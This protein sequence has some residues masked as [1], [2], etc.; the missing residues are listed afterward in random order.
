MSSRPNILLIQSDQH[1]GQVMGCAGDDIVRTP[2]LDGLAESGVIFDNCQ[3][4]APL[5][6]PSRMTMLAGR[7]C[8]DIDVWSNQCR[9][10]SD[11]PTFAHALGAGGYETVLCGRMHFTGPDQRHGFQKRIFGELSDHRYWGAPTV[12]LGDVPLSTTGQCRESVEV[13]G[14]GRTSYQ[15]YDEEVAERA[16]QFLQQRDDDR[17]LFLT[18]GFVLPH[19]PFIAEKE[20]FEYYYDRVGVP[21]VPDGYC[22]DMPEPMRRWREARGITELT[23]EE[24]RTARAG[25]YGIVE[26]FDAVVGRLLQALEKSGMADNTIVIYIS[27]HGESAGKNGLWWKSQFYDHAVGVPMIFSGPGT[28]SGERVEDIVS[29]LDLGPTLTEMGDAPQMQDISGQSMVALMNGDDPAWRNEAISEM[30]NLRP[31]YPYPGRMIRKGPWK[32][33][34]YEGADPILFNLD[35]DPNEFLNRADD[36]HCRKICNYLHERV[37]SGWN[38]DRALRILKRRRRD[39]ALLTDWYEAW[40]DPPGPGDN[41]DHWP[42]PE[43]TTNFPMH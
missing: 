19:C 41:R 34:H 15:A 26:H 11:V 27:D 32:L 37:R 13:S 35:E 25:Y 20:R 42:A 2:N 1:S 7:H 4:A 5:C 17:P 18:A 16:E 30:I 38:P 23:D 43:G 9:L 6:V 40:P 12:N 21:E 24:I 28:P 10:P 33:I 3:C 29:L 14:P 39:R 36:P 31:L 22:E 8:S